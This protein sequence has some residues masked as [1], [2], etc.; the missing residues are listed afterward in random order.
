MVEREVRIAA[1]PE[2]VFGFFCDPE[3]K[4]R[5]MGVQA[6]LDPVPGGIYRVRINSRDV[7]RGEYVEVVPHER[8]VFT[9]GWED[10]GNAV[11]PGASTVEVTLVPDGEGTLLRFVHR[12]LPAQ[13][14]PPHDHG[15]EHYL[16]RLS[17]AASGGDPGPDEFAAARAANGEA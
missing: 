2:T 16:E 10:E 6:E 14:I 12:D 15:W 8:I 13:S 9:W 4:L 1:S 11:P 17:V 3:L 5:W 7:A